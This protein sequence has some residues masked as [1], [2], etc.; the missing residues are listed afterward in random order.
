[1]RPTLVQAH[2]YRV[3]REALRAEVV[4]RD[5]A[6]ALVASA[7][8]DRAS[9]RAALHGPTTTFRVVRRVFRG[10]E[11]PVPEGTTIERP[12]RRTPGEPVP[13]DQPNHIK[14]RPVY[15]TNAQ[16][17]ERRAAALSANTAEMLA[18]KFA[19]E[20]MSPHYAQLFAE[21]I[22]NPIK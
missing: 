21:Q 8:S 4:A 5:E 14:V 6:N 19:A 11:I 1:M 7:Y 22:K 15:P 17:R 20:G 2:A 10:Q 3:A 12:K 16:E 18:D 13:F 9:L